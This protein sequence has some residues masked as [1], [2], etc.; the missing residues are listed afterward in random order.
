MH[1]WCLFTLNATLR[2]LAIH[3]PLP[4]QHGTTNNSTVPVQVGSST[5]W[6]KV[7]ANNIESVGLQS[8]GS[9]WFWGYHLL[10]FGSNATILASPT[11]LSPDTNWVDVGLGDFM[12]F[13]IKSDGTLWAWGADADVYTGAPD[14][15][16]N[17]TPRQV[18]TNHDWRACAPFWNCCTLVM[19]RD[20]S[21]WALDD[22]LDQRGKRLGNPAWKM[23]PVPLRRIGIQKDIVAFSGGRHRLGVAVTR[24][25][26]VWTWGW[27]LGQQSPAAAVVQALSQFLN[28]A[29]V[30]NKWGQGR[31]DPVIH[32]EPW[33]LSNLPPPS[34]ALARRRKCNP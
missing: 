11:R 5:N 30:R 1:S 21:L 25:G 22:V 4:K 18:G 20:G 16:L 23:Q 2:P 28:R 27:A 32:P 34:S 19:K 14:S 31:P 26:E 12:G 33:Q 24:D 17:A 7:W 10:Q 9:L 15:A 29:G 8:D 13:A 6:I 3:A